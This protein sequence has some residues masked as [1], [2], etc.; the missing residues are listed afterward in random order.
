[1][2]LAETE[3][4]A[5]QAAAAAA[6]EWERAS[7]S[8]SD[9]ETE[10]SRIGAASE[11]AAEEPAVIS[12]E[13]A[14]D[15]EK[16]VARHREG[17]TIFTR[18]WQLRAMSAEERKDRLESHRMRRYVMAVEAAMEAGPVQTSLA[19]V[20]DGTDDDDV[21]LDMEEEDDVTSM[22]SVASWVNWTR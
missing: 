5:T 9:D 6:S 2:R 7:A 15:A 3:G 19:G 14:A 12:T 13:S 18:L 4:G 21:G 1:V 16:A 22:G 8:M 17:P 20:Y 10:I 11:G